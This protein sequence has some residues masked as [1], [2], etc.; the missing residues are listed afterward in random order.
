M[1]ILTFKMFL[2]NNF[3]V[4]IN[5]NLKSDNIANKKLKFNIKNVLITLE[6]ISNSI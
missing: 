2:L 1:K 5:I 4:E 3:F 6:K